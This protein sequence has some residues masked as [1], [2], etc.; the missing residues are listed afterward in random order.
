MTSR[1]CINVPTLIAALLMAIPVGTALAQD[2]AAERKL[3]DIPRLTV[4]GESHIEVPAD[5]LRLNIGVQTEDEE[6]PRAV[7][8]NS[9]QTRD[10]IDAIE[11]AG[12]TEDEYE[13]GRFRL[14]PVYSRRP[15]A[16]EPDWKPQIIGY[17]V[18]NSIAV[19]TTRL[20]LAGDLIAA[21]NKAGAN[22]IDTVGF[23]LADRRTGREEAIAEATANAIADARTLA[24]AASLDLLRILS[25]HL[26]HRSEPAS[27]EFSRGRVAS[28]MTGEKPPLT[29]GT[30]AVEATVTIVYEIAPMI[31]Q[32]Q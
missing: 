31:D 2:T 18:L 15:R 16:A 4:K 11:L 24:R 3:E 10:V 6:A 12:L 5:L 26:D 28:A 9:R 23:D 8:R 20:D 25:I 32:H 30:V 17:E 21:A 22:T 7:D 29:P 14:R 1:R 19:K 27:L 13:T